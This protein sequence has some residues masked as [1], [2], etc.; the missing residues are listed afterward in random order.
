M[1]F[2]Y[3]KKYQERI[4]GIKLARLAISKTRQHQGLGKLMMIHAIK[5]VVNI[6]ENVGIVGFF[7]DAKD[8]AAKTYYEQFEFISLPNHPL[9]LFLPLATLQRLHHDIWEQGKTP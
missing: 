2:N 7:V 6:S 5:R 8:E 9:E 4:P 1:P 3:A